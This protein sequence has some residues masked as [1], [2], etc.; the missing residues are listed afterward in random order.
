LR[1]VPGLGNPSASSFDKKITRFTNYT[2]ITLKMVGEMLNEKID[3]THANKETH[4][5]LEKRLE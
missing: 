5:T 2:T 1:V 4:K 3:D